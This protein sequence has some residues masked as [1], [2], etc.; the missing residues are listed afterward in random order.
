MVNVQHERESTVFS[1]T[2]IDQGLEWYSP[3]PA[4]T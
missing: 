1:H 3:D 2:D 4:G